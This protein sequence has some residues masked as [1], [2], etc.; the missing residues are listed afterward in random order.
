MLYLAFGVAALTEGTLAFEYAILCA[1]VDQA[2]QLSL[3]EMT[4][5]CLVVLQ[6]YIQM[7]LWVSLL[8][9]VKVAL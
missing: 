5:C 7:L 1:T 9:F 4:F 3:V 8:D 6:L 2:S